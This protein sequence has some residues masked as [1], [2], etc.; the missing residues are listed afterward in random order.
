MPY[1][2]NRSHNGSRSTLGTA[3]H[4]ITPH[5]TSTNPTLSSTT[6]LQRSLR[7]KKPRSEHFD[8]TTTMYTTKSPH[9]SN[10]LIP[11]PVDFDQLILDRI[12]LDILADE[13]EKYK[14][15]VESGLEDKNSLRSNALLKIIGAFQV[16]K[17][18]RASRS[19]TSSRALT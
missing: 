17:K 1:D 2:P 12:A 5:N 3:T 18:Q 8:T 11:P 10:G 15:K 9:H 14:D 7:D 19:T 4:P 16:S 6:S 13:D